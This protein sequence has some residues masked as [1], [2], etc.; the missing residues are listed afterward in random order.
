MK[1]IVRGNDFT[2]RIPVCKIVNGEQVA[3]PL[4]ACTDIVVNIVNQYRRVAL[5]YAIDTAEDNVINAR[6]EGDAVSVGTYALEVRGKIFGNDWRSKEY[7]QFSIVDNNAS[8]DTAFN[9]ELIEGEESVEMNTALVILPPTAE[10]TQLITDAN[11]AL[12]TA[13]QTDATLK[14]NESE[15]TEAEQQRASAE[16]QRVSEESKR[17]ESEGVRHAAEV[18]RV[19]NEDAR[20]T[21]EAQRAN[22]ESERVEAE[23][24]RTTNET[25]RAA[26]EEQRTT[27]FDELTANVNTAVSKANTAASAANTATDK[28][29]AEESKRAEAERQ[30]ATAEATRKQNENTRLEAESERTNNETAREAAETARQNAETERVNKENE[31]KTSESNRE[32]AEQ[33]RVSAET[34]RMSNEDARK[35]AELERVN[36]ETARQTAESEREAAEQERK[37]NETERKAAETQRKEAEEARTAAEASRV[38]AE[39][40]REATLAT[41]KANCEAATKKASDAASEATIATSKANASAE[42]ANAAAVAAEN[43]D[44]ALA[45]DVLTVTNRKG[46]STSLQLASYAEV[47]DVVSEVKHLSETMGAY[48]DRP[49]IVLTAKETN[50]AISASGAKVSKSGWA[51]AE[52]TAEKGNVYLF[53]PNVI[54]DSVC[55]FAEYIQSVETRGI[56]YTYTYN[57]DGTTATAT[58][59]YLGATHTYT[60]TYAEDKSC[61]ITDETGAAVDALPMVYETKV[62]TYSSL[63][64]LNADAELP[65]DGYCRYMSHFKGNSAIKV[66][67]SYKVGV[68]DLTMKVTRDGVLASISTQLGNLSQKEDETRKKMDELHGSY[69]DLVFYDVWNKLVVDGKTI[70]VIKGQRMRLYPTK[71]FSIG[72][73]YSKEVCPL[74]FADMSHLD[75]SRFTTFEFMF[76]N[77]RNAVIIGLENLDTGS[78]TSMG[79][80]FSGCSSL[81][82]LNINGWN[83]GSVTSMASMFSGCTALTTLNI[84][85]FNGRKLKTGSTAYNG[86]IGLLFFGCK[87]LKTLDMSGDDWCF[88]SMENNSYNFYRWLD[89]TAVSSLTLGKNWFKAEFTPG[90]FVALSTWNK[91]SV[92]LSLVT[93]SYD[94]KANGLT[95]KTITLHANVKKLLSE[96]DIAAMTAKG[97]IIA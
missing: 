65:K 16:A 81:T 20:K 27:T 6:V 60:Y 90:D 64:S 5:S 40:Q 17:S 24:T 86:G 26:A 21:A 85:S 31:R 50:K 73:Q 34:E 62:G 96:D 23:K 12:E 45:N 41:I 72:D 14:A 30:R 49:D 48:T 10:L 88:D 75:T 82:T 38:S 95:D 8:G 2:L 67:V 39:E 33:Q 22:A 19:S 79:N 58:A 78:V 77:C 37:T 35:T 53:K 57:S 97:Y 3:F 80:M 28:A 83:T 4:P 89:G 61:V 56:D 7:E 94:R 25:A 68:A 92:R 66:V 43:V 52:F 76:K 63:V 55:I 91:E 9:G 11:T 42:K 29:N 18:E 46:E 54:D 70:P 71:S 74:A 93:N 84:S 15:R 59:T 1:K 87:N 44:A 32:L 69:V 47:G 51:I 36:E 13:K